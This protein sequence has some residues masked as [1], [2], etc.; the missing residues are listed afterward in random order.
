MSSS[1]ANESRPDREAFAELERAESAALD[2]LAA[3]RT[4]AQE[5]ERRSAELEELVRRFT[6]DEAEAGRL[7]SRLRELEAESRELRERMDAARGGVDRL[8]S[9]V[10][11]LEGR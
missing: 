6:G 10:R 3:A 1:E 5:A 11:Y 2:A 4:R 9:R 7:L 8:L